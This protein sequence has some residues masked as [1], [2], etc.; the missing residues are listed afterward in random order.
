MLTFDTYCT[1][2]YV[3]TALVYHTNTHIHTSVCLAC[4][5]QTF[6]PNDNGDLPPDRPEGWKPG[7]P[8]APGR[9]ERE[10]FKG[11]CP[12]LCYPVGVKSSEARRFCR[13][14]VSLLCWPRSLCRWRSPSGCWSPA[15]RPG[16]V[17]E[18]CWAQRCR[19]GF[20][21]RG[22]RCGK[23]SLSGRGL[24]AAGQ[25]Q[26]CGV[27]RSESRSPT[28]GWCWRHRSCPGRLSATASCVSGW[29]WPGTAREWVRSVWNYT[30]KLWFEVE[31]T[32]T[33]FKHLIITWI[34]PNGGGLSN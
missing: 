30:H 5:S 15:W 26:D 9:K 11:P 12:P 22:M 23:R 20:G 31:E 10:Q 28:L 8:T 19:W 29:V 1:V 34:K 16:R 18:C 25:R 27:Y 2:L 4:M 7:P 24:W 32:F 3:R 17:A 14:P 33:L 21:W 6:P 13:L